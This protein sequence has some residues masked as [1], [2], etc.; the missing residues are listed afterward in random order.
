MVSDQQITEIATLID[1]QIKKQN[2]ISP[3][4]RIDAII[5][6]KRKVF[7]K[8]WSKSFLEHLGKSSFKLNI[9]KHFDGIRYIVKYR[10]PDQ[11]L[12][13]FR[14]PIT[15]AKRSLTNTIKEE[16][17]QIPKNMNGVIVINSDLIFHGYV[18]YAEETVK[19]N[20]FSN[21]LA[22]IIWREDDYKIVHRKNISEG[23]F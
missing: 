13:L 23:S 10:T 4:M 2:L 1:G 5:T 8:R 7:S 6:D 14:A 11:G 12:F 17:K 16:S 15:S 22:I 21:I 19:S 3:K 9:W 18:R 20:K